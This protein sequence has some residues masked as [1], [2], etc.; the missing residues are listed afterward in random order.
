LPSF[1]HQALTVL[2][3]L[4]AP[5]NRTRLANLLRGLQIVPEAAQPVSGNTRLQRK[6]G[7]AASS[8]S[9]STQLLKPIVE[10]WERL[11]LVQI[12]DGDYVCRG[13]VAHAVLS[14]CAQVISAWY[15]RSGS[16]TNPRGAQGAM[17]RRTRT[18]L[19]CRTGSTSHRAC[20]RGAVMATPPAAL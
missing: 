4:G 8:A 17:A 15:S 20:R 7:R 10:R 13:W 9:A 6:P 1:E 14:D 11:G 19:R 16:R 12:E 18:T 5:L 2:A 3:A